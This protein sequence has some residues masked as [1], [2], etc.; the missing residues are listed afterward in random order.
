MKKRIS[1][2]GFKY[3][4][5]N[6]VLYLDAIMFLIIPQIP[7]NLRVLMVKGCGNFVLELKQRV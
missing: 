2:I 7:L 3:M 6:T 5:L 4:V 1:N